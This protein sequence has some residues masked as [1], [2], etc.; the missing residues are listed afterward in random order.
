MVGKEKNQVLLL[1]KISPHTGSNQQ[2]TDDKMGLC[3]EGSLETRSSATF[4]YLCLVPLPWSST[5]EQQNT[6]PWRSW[7]S[8]WTPRLCSVLSKVS[9]G[10]LS[11]PLLSMESTGNHLKD[12]VLTACDQSEAFQVNWAL[13]TQSRLGAM[14][15]AL[16]HLVSVQ[17][18]RISSTNSSAPH[19]QES[20]QA[21]ESEEGGA[22]KKPGTCLCPV[23]WQYLV[24]CILNH[25]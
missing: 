23:S 7:M 19:C 10:S 4:D 18:H 3:M 22:H 17:E 12:H 9:T 6:L 21:K 5:K 13:A 20:L 15:I 16:L 25:P 11:L 1:C 24:W 14:G 8:A 2:N